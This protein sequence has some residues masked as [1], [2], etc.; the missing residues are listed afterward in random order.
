MGIVLSF[1]LKM[2]SEYK[3]TADGSIEI[4][5][6]RYA[7]QFDETTAFYIFVH[8]TETLG[9]KRVWDKNVTK[10]NTQLSAIVDHISINMK[11]L[12][13]FM[14]NMFQDPDE[15][16][17]ENRENLT[18]FFSTVFSYAITTV[19][20]AD[21]Q[22]SRPELVVAVF[23]SVLLEGDII[24]MQ[25][26]IQFLTMKESFIIDTFTDDQAMKKYM[27]EEMMV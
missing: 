21:F 6:G 8:L 22:N 18:R 13:N 11:N 4:Q 12:Y 16:P 2:T 19:F 17:I 14:Y 24:I 23:E 1:I 25:L 9:Y 26:I 10:L 15:S 5:N 3:K 7:L 27:R 20:V